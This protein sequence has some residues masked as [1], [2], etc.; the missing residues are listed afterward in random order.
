MAKLTD[1]FFNRVIEGPLVL[2]DVEKAQVIEA[3]E[4]DS[5][6]KIF[7]NIVDKDG[8]KRFI[9][10]DITIETIEGVTQT[11]GKWSLSG[12]H[13]MIVVGANFANASVIANGK[14]ANINL[15][16]WIVDKITP[17]FSTIAIR[18]NETLWNTDYSSQT[19]IV[20]VEKQDNKIVM[21]NGPLTLTKDRVGRFEFDLLIDNASA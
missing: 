21:Y 17:L 11:Y 12:S 16:Q 14:L 2:E 1:K 10:G 6:I 19:L 20:N 4:A 5:N 9:E 8:H 13:L 15:P 18:H 3:V 7:E